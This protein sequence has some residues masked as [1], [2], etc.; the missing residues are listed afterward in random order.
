MTARTK[1]ARVIQEYNILQCSDR[2]LG[3]GDSVR[4]LWNM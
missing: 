1:M 2:H 3:E 4:E